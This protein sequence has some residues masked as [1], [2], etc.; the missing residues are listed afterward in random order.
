MTS[1]TIAT[2]GRAL[3]PDL[4][5]GAMLLAIA[6]AHAPLF[7]LAVD[8]GPTL[9]N[10]AALVFHQLFVHNHARPMFAFL[11]GYAMVQMLDRWT[12]K[13]SDRADVR[14]S[15]RRRGWWLVVFGAVHTLLV[16]LDVLAL[17]GIV[18]VLLVGLLW[19]RNTTLLVVGG[20]LLVPATLSTGMGMW[21]SLSEGVTTFDTGNV[22]V[23]EMYGAGAFVERVQTWPFALVFGG[24]SVAPPL[25]FGMWAAR[26]RVLEAPK[27]HCGFLVRAVVATMTVSTLGAL[28]AVLILTRAW[29]DPGDTALWGTALVQPLTG[30]FGGMGLAGI[31]ALVAIRAAWSRGRMTA[32]TAA[33]GQRSMTFY[34]LQTPVFIVCFHPWGLGLY[35]D[36]GLAGAFGIAV[37]TWL[38]S[39]VVAEFMA[40]RGHRGPT[41]RL[42]RWLTARTALP[43]R[44]ESRPSGP[45][46][47]RVS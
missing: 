10:E 27:R 15:L 22:G 42:L 5:R 43:R 4:A 30:Y 37:A 1:P 6:F 19:A 26:R 25:V 3:A 16:P 38:G 35:D 18:S 34:L 7:V 24:L 44:N 40:R 28:P 29:A 9:A 39:L 47:P 45:D 31:V 41:E 11:L 36:V 17:Y 12:A 14:R 23:T 32:A 2:E 21:Q 20:L 8:H 13:G 46:V 33:L